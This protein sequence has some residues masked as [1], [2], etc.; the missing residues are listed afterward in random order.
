[1]TKKITQSDI[2][3]KLNV[4]RIT[5]S[6]VLNSEPGV[7]DSMRERIIQTAIEMGYQKL[8][9]IDQFKTEK[10]VPMENKN[11]ILI[12]HD[13]SIGN[14][15]WSYIVQGLTDIMN[16]SPYNLII[17][18]ISKEDE[19]E[20]LLG[21]K[22]VRDNTAGLILVGIFSKEYMQKIQTEKIP[23]VFV[24]NQS[25]IDMKEV[26]GDVVMMENENSVY[27]LIAHIISKGHTSIGFVGDIILCGSFMERWY[28]FERAM[29]KAGL[30]IDESCCIKHHSEVPYY[31]YEEL[32]SGIHNMKENLPTAFVCVNDN[33]AMLVMRILN[34]MGKVIPDDI[35]IVGFDDIDEA[36]YILPN[37]TTV[38]CKKKELGRR[39]GE[40]IL[41]R[42]E[43]PERPFEKIYVSTEVVLRDSVKDVS[44]GSDEI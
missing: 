43:N 29:N 5:V 7:S 8:S 16:K 26:K 14:T 32:V 6:K 19:R 4:S 27:N 34:I 17:N 15:F 24:D 28:G 25:A 39:I 22:H 13:N 40:E 23:M 31:S 21:K 20:Y 9:K 33:T 38:R 30:K 41:W 2:A 3:N 44:L 18:I 10:V 36:S 11:I 1:M 35:S 37:L 42:I 12:T